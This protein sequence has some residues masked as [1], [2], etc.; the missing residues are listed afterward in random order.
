[1]DLNM[2]IV[3][4]I[5]ATRRISQLLP[6]ARVVAFSG[7]D[8]AD[9]I[10]AMM[11][12]GAAAYCV[13][14]APLWELERAIAGRSDPLVRLAHGLARTTN[15][16]G[17]G[18][19]VCR[20]LVE[21]TGAGAAAVYLASPDVALSLAGCAG[22]ASAEQLAAAP[23]MALRAFSTLGSIVADGAD[24]AELERLGIASADALAVPLISDGEALGS[25][26]L[27]MP[28][29]APLT[30]DEDFVADIAALAAS[31]VA[32]E[33]RLALTH[34]EARRDALTGL[35]NRRAYEERLDEAFRAA[36][37][38]GSEISIV[39][40]DLDGFKQINDTGGHAAGD[41]VLAQVGRAAQRVLRAGEELFRVGGDEF[42]LVVDG[43]AAVGVEVAERVAAALAEQTRGGS[44]PTISAGVASYPE[45][46]RTKTELEIAADNALYASK[47]R[48]RSRAVPHRPRG[49]SMA[50][51]REPADHP[52]AGSRGAR[53][54]F[55]DDDP[56][57]LMLLRT[58][59]ELIDIEFGEAHTAAA[60][61]AAVAARPPD[62]VVLDIGL[63]DE[64]GL[65]LCR[66]LKS[67]AAT[68]WIGVVLLTGSGEEAEEPAR[69]AGADAFL[70]KPFS[71]L[72]LLAIVER[73]AGGL[74]EGPFGGTAP[75]AGDE[76]LLLYANDLRRLL[77]IERGRQELLQR[78]YRQTVA[79]LA[80][81]LESKDFGTGLHSQRVQRYAIEL[82]E[83]IEPQLLLDP[84][85]EYGF[86]LHDVGKIGIPDHVLQKRGPLD[87]SELRLMRT[88]TVL[89]EQLLRDVDLLHGTGLRVVRGHHERWDGLGYPDGLARAEI[90]LAARIF[91]VADALDAITSDRPYRPARTWDDAA[92]EIL[93]ER[94][95]QFD[96][97]VV[98]A[99]R[100][101]EHVL[102]GIRRELALA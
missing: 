73:L 9:A 21:L 74:Y 70:R 92:A 14:G 58:T 72:E 45:G 23:A 76:Q 52:P 66:R 86:L 29:N 40:F 8:D 44:L 89:G 15:R 93:A 79:T 31:A 101:R 34:A 57:L 56:A 39:V 6:E 83:A 54:L 47:R 81:A 41:A 46:A 11:E 4:G 38:C 48:E 88:H 85:V 65:T 95:R 51:E 32:A 50:G 91:T 7:I 77:Q 1:M 42:A 27:T 98:D 19:I 62:V 5:E 94:G 43:G 37:V 55:V 63:P 99:F 100:E 97:D 30:A 90:P 3:D 71:P 28:S 25:L 59:F 49:G 35:A 102:R 87:D 2:P 33:R 61:T 22:D 80:S 16:A 13:K 69:R 84:S 36:A 60:A 53:V 67:D 26:L 24:L 18:T 78:T 96:P 10:G 12:A 75:A 68:S 64:D 17:I 82:A 20:E